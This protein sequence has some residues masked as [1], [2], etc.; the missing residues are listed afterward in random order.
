MH[1]YCSLIHASILLNMVY[2]LQR[3]YAEYIMY[4]TQAAECL[5]QAAQSSLRNGYTDLIMQSCHCFVE[6]VDNRDAITSC[7]FLALYQVGI[8]TLVSNFIKRRTE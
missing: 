2:S 5:A 1:M 8:I 7:Q 6:C 4:I 3:K